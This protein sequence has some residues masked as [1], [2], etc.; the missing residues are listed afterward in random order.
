[1]ELPREGILHGVDRVRSRGATG[2][3]LQGVFSGIFDQ[4][5]EDIDA[6]LERFVGSGVADAEVCI[7]FAEDASWDDQ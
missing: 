5:E 4:V 7:L 6:S 3:F 1:M 2:D